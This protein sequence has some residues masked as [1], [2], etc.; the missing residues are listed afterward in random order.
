MMAATT[1]ERIANMDERIALPRKNGELVF[2][3]PWEARAFGLAVALNE[4]GVYPWSDFSQGLAR[5]IAT[6]ESATEA[7]SYYEHWLATLEALVIANGLVTPQELEAMIEE[8][9]LLDDHD[10]EHGHHHHD[11]HDPDDHDHHTHH[12]HNGHHH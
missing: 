11:D 12:H 7:S 6:A 3:S 2:E 5:E 8:Q 4:Q 1:D 9:A 10:H